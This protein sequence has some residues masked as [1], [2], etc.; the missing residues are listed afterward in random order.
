[1]GWIKV[2]HDLWEKPEVIEMAHILDISADHVV[3][4]LIRVWSWADKHTENGR[5]NVP[6]NLGQCPT[7]VPHLSHLCLACGV[8]NLTKAMQEVGWLVVEDDCF[9]ISNFSKHNGEGAKKR[10]QEAARKAAWRESQKCPENVPQKT[11]QERDQKRKEK[12]TNT[13]I[14]PNR[15]P[16]FDEWK[17]KAVPRGMTE[18]EALRTWSYYESV[19][20]MRGK[21]PISKWENCITTCLKDKSQPKGKSVSFQEAREAA[22]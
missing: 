3:G 22:R 1:M 6:Q 12:N 5:V 10:V 17:A 7:N 11:G 13:P 15:K 21:T 16:T 18:S 4:C 2:D 8:P 14:S 9:Y 19:D 20:W